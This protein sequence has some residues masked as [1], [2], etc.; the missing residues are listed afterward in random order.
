[1]A[2]AGP[3]AAS[4][5]WTPAA[6]ATIAAAAARILWRGVWGVTSLWSL[7]WRC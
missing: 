7:H 4:R 6:A 1:M 5:W 3:G 2:A